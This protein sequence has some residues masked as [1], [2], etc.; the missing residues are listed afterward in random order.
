MNYLVGKFF[1]NE[2][3]KCLNNQCLGS[4]WDAKQT[5]LAFEKEKGA[6]SSTQYH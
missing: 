5:Y 3:L 6:L 2:V 4:F 1:V